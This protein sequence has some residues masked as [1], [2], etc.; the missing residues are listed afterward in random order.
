MTMCIATASRLR[1]RRPRVS[2]DKRLCK[3]DRGPLLPRVSRLLRRPTSR[4]S[5]AS[6]P[7]TALS[8]RDR[9]TVLRFLATATALA[10]ESSRFA[11]AHASRTFV[12]L[13][14]RISSLV[15]SDYVYNSHHN[16]S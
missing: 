3:R 9:R 10:T 15:L 7:A 11:T 6:R 2:R 1:D 5:L 4:S 12:L 13:I 16:F 8:H 14:V